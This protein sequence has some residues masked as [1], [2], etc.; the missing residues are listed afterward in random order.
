MS[1]TAEEPA[2]TGPAQPVQRAFEVH[3]RGRLI[4]DAA[5]SPRIPVALRHDPASDPRA[6]SVVLPTAEPG[7]DRGRRQDRTVWTF[8]RALLE[9]GLR[10]PAEQGDVRIWPCGR[11]QAVLELHTARG[12]ALVQLDCAPVVSFLRRTYG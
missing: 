10:T 6:V 2:V 7:Q 3:L 11:V 12:V 4:T 9:A 8:P 1:R 5:V